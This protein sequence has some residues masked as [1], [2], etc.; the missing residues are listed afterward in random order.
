[1][2]SPGGGAVGDLGEGT[3][4][5][6]MLLVVNDVHPRP[7][8]SNDDI[9]LGEGGAREAVGLIETREQERPF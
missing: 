6:D 1:M 9:V 8:N 4:Q 2:I 7:I 3:F 5:H